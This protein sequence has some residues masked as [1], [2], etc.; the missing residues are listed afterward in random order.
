M[1]SPN[2]A[3]A[4]AAAA[5]STR[6]DRGDERRGARRRA[7]MLGSRRH[8]RGGARRRPR[9]RSSFSAVSNIALVFLTAVLVERHRLWAVA[10]ALRL[11]RQRARLQFLLPAAALH[12]HHRRSRKRRRAVLLR[13]RRGDRQQSDR[14]RAQPGAWPRAARARPP[15][16]STSSAASSP[17]SVTLDDLLWATAY[18]IASMLKVRV[19][20][21]LPEGETIAVR[22]GYPPEDMLDE[23]DLAAAKWCWENNR[24]GRA[25]APTP[26]PGAKRLFLPMRT[27][28]GAGRRG[29]PRQRPARAAADAR[30]AAAARRARRPGGARDR[31]DRRW[32][33]TSIA[34]ALAGR[35]RAAALG[36]ADLDLPRSAHAAWPRSSARSTSLEN[37]RAIA[38]RGGADE[39][40]GTIQDEA[41]RL[42]RFIGNLLDMTRLESGAIEPHAEMVDLAEIV[43]SALERAAKVLAEHT[44]SRWI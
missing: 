15:R 40:I 35:D 24:A 16:I 36:A 41:E 30:P 38:R 5:T 10:V 4:S 3:R 21:L 14:A 25:A 7:P 28:R 23:A 29:R 9:P 33:R 43:G 37:Y 27:G 6:R 18:Q 32:P 8:G 2:S 11:P 17:A 42:N 12:L 39:L 19:V 44:T 34:R 22:A 13:R 31:A 1:S 26:C 20:L